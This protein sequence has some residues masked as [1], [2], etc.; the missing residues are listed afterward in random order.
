M[1]ICEPGVKKLSV[2]PAAVVNV[3]NLN[4]CS[5][6]GV[7]QFDHFRLRHW[8]SATTPG[9][10][11]TKTLPKIPR[12]VITMTCRFSFPLDTS[13]LVSANYCYG[14]RTQALIP[15]SVKL[16]RQRDILAFAVE[17][18]VG[19]V[20]R[21][22][23]A[24]APAPERRLKTV[25]FRSRCAGMHRPAPARPAY[26]SPLLRRWL[27]GCL[28]GHARCTLSLPGLAAVISHLTS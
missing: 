27:A 18:S 19:P 26:W 7:E 23:S 13:S 17:V 8:L 25:S 9:D 15:C 1:F 22:I 11:D 5:G 16:V 6:V 14:S 2:C 28:M 24:L 3:K 20:I 4:K 12:I 10:S 21:V